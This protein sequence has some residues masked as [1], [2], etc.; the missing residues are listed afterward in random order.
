M[1]QFCVGDIVIVKGT[2]AFAIGTAVSQRLLSDSHP[3]VT[4]LDALAIKYSRPLLQQ[5]SFLGSCGHAASSL[6]AKRGCYPT[7][8]KGCMF[9]RAD[10][11]GEE[12]TTVYRCLCVDR[13]GNITGVDDERF[14]RSVKE[15][16]LSKTKVLASLEKGQ[17]VGLWL[18]RGVEGIAYCGSGHAVLLNEKILELFKW[19]VRD[20]FG[21]YGTPVKSRVVEL[22][23][24]EVVVEYSESVGEHSFDGLCDARRCR[25]WPFKDVIP[26]EVSCIDEALLSGVDLSSPS[27]P[28][29]CAL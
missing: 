28:Y 24:E 1:S 10:K 11:R 22:S 9:R 29:Y 27:S 7:P 20:R 23:H 19:G 12:F 2:N 13:S 21:C 14:E 15:H 5:G 26:Q 6:F 4:I 25:C 17:E 8:H 16:G 18:D 3:T